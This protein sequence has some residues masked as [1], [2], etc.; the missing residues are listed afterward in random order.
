MYVTKFIVLFMLSNWKICRGKQY[1]PNTFC[2]NNSLFW[3]VWMRERGQ[4]HQCVYVQLLRPQIPKVQKAARVDCLFYAF[5]ICRRRSCTY[6]VD[7]IDT[8]RRRRKKNLA[9]ICQGGVWGV[10]PVVLSQGGAAPIHRDTTTTTQSKTFPEIWRLWDQL[11][12][13]MHI[14]S[15]V[16]CPSVTKDHQS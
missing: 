13:I 3:N 6:N 5:G 15:Y 10:P 4:F 11:H 1:R 9:S 8:R 7:E 2:I 12:M 16:V 14:S